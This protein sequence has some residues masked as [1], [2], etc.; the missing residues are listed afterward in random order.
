[1]NPAE[2]LGAIIKDRVD[3]R[4]LNEG[5]ERYSHQTLLS[6]LQ[7]VLHNLEHDSELFAE[8]LAYCHSGTGWMLLLLLLVATLITN[9]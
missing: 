6:N 3:D 1:L 2:D 8:L 7:T 9:L 4:M 5:H